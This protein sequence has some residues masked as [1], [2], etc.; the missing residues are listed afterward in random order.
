MSFSIGQLARAAGVPV[1]TVRYYERVGLVEPP[2]RTEKGH[3]IYGQNELAR[4]RCIRRAL[5]GGFKLDDLDVLRSGVCRD[6]SRTMD[7]RLAEIDERVGALRTMRDTL[8]SLRELCLESDPQ[9]CPVP[10]A[11]YNAD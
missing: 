11:L 5:A 9:S 6:I 7:T 8:A 1:S 2:E 4:L 10:R 3:R